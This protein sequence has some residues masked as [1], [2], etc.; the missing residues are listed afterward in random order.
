MA[1]VW[2]VT[3]SL[4]DGKGK[5]SQVSFNLPSATTLATIE[6]R[7]QAMLERLAILTDC[8][9]D[10]KATASITIPLN[11]PLADNVANLNSDVEEGARFTYRDAGGYSWSVRI[12]GFY[13]TLLVAQNSNLV[14]EANSNVLAFNN[15]VL[16]NGWTDA[17]G[18]DLTE[19]A[20]ALD[21]FKRSGK[22]R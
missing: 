2:Q 1:R 10:T 18:A 22:R 12:P 21:E 20:S 15:E 7:A 9:V 19:L 8:R 4:I 5:R 14:N 16:N 6:T 13:E 11:E 17:R 3:Y